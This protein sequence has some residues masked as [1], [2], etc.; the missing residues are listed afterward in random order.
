VDKPRVA[1]TARCDGQLFARR[2]HAL[3]KPGQMILKIAGDKILEHRR[4]GQ[5]LSN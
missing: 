5:M 4:G 1:V 2:S 3:V